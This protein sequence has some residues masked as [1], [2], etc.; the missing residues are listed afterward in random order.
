MP[1]ALEQELL[2]EAEHLAQPVHGDHLQLGA[3]GTRDP[4]EANAGN[5][6]GQDVSHDGRVAVGCREVGV[7]LQTET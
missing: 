4:G 3:G 1:L 6:P 5:R 2:G 7:E